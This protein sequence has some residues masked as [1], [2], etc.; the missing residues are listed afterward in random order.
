MRFVSATILTLV[1]NYLLS[2]VF[3]WWSIAIGAGLI[4]V[5]VRQI[6]G[7]SLLSGFC[8]GFLHWFLVAVLIDSA[9]NHI[10][11]QRIA[12]VFSL[13]Q[14]FMMVLITAFAGGLVSGLSALTI[15]LLKT[16]KQNKPITA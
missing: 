1:L 7:M 5:F 16:S 10:L 2:L 12:G 3:P 9:N 8:G 13:P 11:S 14:P 15:S 6:P 4:A